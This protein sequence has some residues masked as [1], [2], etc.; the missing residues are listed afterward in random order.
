[1]P[2]ATSVI[3]AS[4]RHDR[5]VAD[6]V[7]L[8]YAMRS[9]GEGVVTSVKGNTI[10]IH[11][12]GGLRLRTDDL[13]VLDDGTLVEVVAAPEALIEARAADVAALARLAWHLGDRHIAVQLLPNR[14]RARRDEAV[15][16]LLAALGAKVALIDAPF[17]PEG[18]A[19]APPPAQAHDHVHDAHCGH[20]H[21]H[22]H[23]HDHGHDHHHDHGHSHHG[24]KHD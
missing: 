3:A 16:T 1:M 6:T 19:Y 23:A 21:N 20:D 9:A 2:R 8:D 13:L 5:P 17:E 22:D 15:A 7:I 12:H 18:G 4:H 10:E 14:I 24:H 11:L